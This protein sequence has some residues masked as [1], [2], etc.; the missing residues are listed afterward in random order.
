MLSSTNYIKYFLLFLVI[1][2]FL[3]TNCNNPPTEQ[4]KK[5]WEEYSKVAYINV[6]NKSGL[7]IK[8]INFFPYDSTSRT[9]NLINENDTIINLLCHGESSYRLFVILS[10]GDTLKT[11]GNYYEGGYK[12]EEVIKSDTIIT[13]Y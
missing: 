10:N 1:S 7:T 2:L 5:A 9:V 4:E 6:K 12:L 13:K 3:N 8:S 11:H